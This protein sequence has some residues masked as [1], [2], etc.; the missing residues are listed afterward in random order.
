M[1]WMFLIFH[2]KEN[3]IRKSFYQRWKEKWN[4]TQNSVWEDKK[5]WLII[6]QKQNILL[7]M[8][9]SRKGCRNSHWV[10]Q[11]CHKS[12][13]CQND[14]NGLVSHA[15]SWLLV[16]FTWGRMIV[17]CQSDSSPHIT[18]HLTL[19]SLLFSPLV[20][21]Q[22][23]LSRARAGLVVAG[24]AAPRPGPVL[25]SRCRYIIYTTISLSHINFTYQHQHLS[26]QASCHP[27]HTNL[28]SLVLWAA[29]LLM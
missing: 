1:F 20:W 18:S 12:L 13:C 22:L 11:N 28:C 8:F 4:R 16:S 15:D 10:W 27:L 7:K 2:K 23:T 6:K 24:T 21:Y 19:H 29:F 5:D 25:L 9:T 3:L 14:E 17:W 26:T